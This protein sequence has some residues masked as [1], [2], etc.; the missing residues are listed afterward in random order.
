LPGFE[1]VEFSSE[2]YRL[3]GDLHW[4][5][6]NAPCILLCHGAV[7][8]KDSEKWL[9]A[10]CSLE[11]AGFAALRFNFRGCGRGDEWSEGDF[12]D[13]TLTTR[14][15]DYKAALDFLAG[16]VNRLGVIGSSFGGCTI[17]AANDPRPRAYVALATPC[18]FE[19]T[20]IMLKSFQEKGYYEYPEAEEPRMSKIRQTL[21]DDFEQYD[22]AE[23]VTKIKHPLLI[24]HGSKD[25]IPVSDARKLY[26]NANQP[27]R[28]E[29]I[30]GGSHIFVDTGHL[31]KVIDLCIEWFKKYL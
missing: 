26:E 5:C 20:P 24:I 9:T 23:A 25:A 14:I 18:K 8:N 4:P 6:K 28:L 29:I 11:D 1:R 19:A 3:I 7:S 2:S 31:G 27:K 12:Q 17:I 30:E 10:A 13:T 16:K 22:M 21:Y 15:R